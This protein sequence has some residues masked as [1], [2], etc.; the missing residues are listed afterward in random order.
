MFTTDGIISMK[1]KILWE[2]QFPFC[3][4]GLLQEKKRLPSVAKQVS[5][6]SSGT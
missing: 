2:K 6:K 4:L 5:K 1:K 3:Q